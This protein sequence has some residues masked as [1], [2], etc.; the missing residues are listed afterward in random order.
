MWFETGT[1]AHRV[2]LTFNMTN[3]GGFP[4]LMRAYVFDVP[5]NLAAKLVDGFRHDEGD[6]RFAELRRV[7]KEP[8]KSWL[9]QLI[10]P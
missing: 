7:S 2:A 1:A 5:L 10:G 9:K 4:Q 6:Y 8:R 3:A